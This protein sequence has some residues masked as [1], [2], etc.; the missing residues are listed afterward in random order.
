MTAGPLAI[1]IA[2][3]LCALTAG[4]LTPWARRLVDSDSRW[5][6]RW[7]GA[8][9]GALGGAGA[10]VVAEHWAVAVALGALAV[11]SALLILVDLA[12]FR[13]PDR[14]VWPTTAAVLGMLVVAAALT[15]WWQRLGTAV[16]AMIVVGL[17]FFAVGW[18]APESFG[19]GDVKASLVLALAL[20]WHGW[21]A[22]LFGMLAGFLLFALA[23]L[24]LLATR[25]A[26]LQSHLAFGPSMILGAACGLAWTAVSA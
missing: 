18:I 13:L 25:R 6:R 20:G 8:L 22:V 9:L 16:L 3:A 5:L 24:A 11:G 10:A 14:I 12:V 4:S 15:G 7:L 1:G 23:A 26:S 2:A 17:V 19:L 21:Q